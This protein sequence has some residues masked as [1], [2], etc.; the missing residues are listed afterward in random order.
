MSPKTLRMSG[1]GKT[2]SASSE[3]TTKTQ[4]REREKKEMKKNWKEVK[5]QK[6]HTKKYKRQTAWQIITLSSET[7]DNRLII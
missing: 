6:S 3:T 5:I 4:E 1:R 2:K 7:Y